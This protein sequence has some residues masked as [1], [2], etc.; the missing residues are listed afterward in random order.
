[1]INLGGARATHAV[2]IRNACPSNLIEDTL[3]QV[4]L[5]DDQI[6]KE[7]ECGETR[8][9]WIGYAILTVVE[10]CALGQGKELGYVVSFMSSH[11]YRT[12]C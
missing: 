11:H 5:F 10:A 3:V 6:I 9:V 7:R 4:V 12:G 8:H 2:F 1:M